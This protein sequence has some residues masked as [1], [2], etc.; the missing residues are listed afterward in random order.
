MKPLK[1]AER[2]AP[3]RPAT[4]RNRPG[5]HR[6]AAPQGLAKFGEPLTARSWRRS[7]RP[8]QATAWPRTGRPGGRRADDARAPGELPVRGAGRRA[9]PASVDADLLRVRLDELE[10][11]ASGDL[12]VRGMLISMVVRRS[13]DSR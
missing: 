13:S 9:E 4:R 1:A 12:D 8:G 2:E 10:V 6:R 5:S 7:G 11:A 3:L